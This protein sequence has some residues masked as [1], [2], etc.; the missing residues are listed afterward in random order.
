MASLQKAIELD[1]N[2]SAAHNNLGN[3]LKESGR[4][5]EAVTCYRRALELSPDYAD[6]HNNIGVLLT[7]QGNLDLATH[8]YWQALNCRPDSRNRPQQPSFLLELR[9][10]CGA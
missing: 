1:P 2:E 10:D 5:D 9:S 3:V 4:L 8:H 7:A 6:A